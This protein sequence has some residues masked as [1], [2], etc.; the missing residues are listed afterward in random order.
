M[1]IH[2]FILQ[3]EEVLKNA[4]IKSPD[5]SQEIVT[6]LKPVIKN[7]DDSAD[8]HLR[9]DPKHEHMKSRLK[10]ENDD[11]FVHDKKLNEA[12]VDDASHPNREYSEHLR[13]LERNHQL[14]T[15]EHS[16]HRPS[17]QP[18]DHTQLKCPDPEEGELSVPKSDS[19]VRVQSDVFC[20][21]FCGW[22]YRMV[23]SEQP[24][25][26]Q[27][28]GDSLRPQLFCANSTLD[29][30][31]I[32]G[33]ATEHRTAAGDRACVAIMQELLQQLKLLFSPNLDSGVQAQ[34]STH[35]LVKVFCCG[36][37]HSGHTF[38][39]IFEQEF[40]LVRSPLDNAW[41]IVYTKI[42]LKNVETVQEPSLPPT[43][44]FAIEY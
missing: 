33:Q 41:K 7:K 37:L 31:L 38:T 4:A 42:N 28:P 13:T 17:F 9:L 1:S 6:T 40:G 16:K 27:L 34:A 8:Q 3:D 26:E 43:D 21:E 15:G 32:Q 22:F 18:I 14:S 24:E 20:R 36:T 10:Q 44:V 29:L 19:R 35:G 11:L 5:N 39:G 25:F 2:I 12:S 30:Y 23:N